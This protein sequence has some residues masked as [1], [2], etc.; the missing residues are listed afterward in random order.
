MPASKG[1]AKPPSGSKSQVKKGKG[2]SPA[3]GDSS[4][5]TNRKNKFAG[6]PRAAKKTW[7]R[8]APGVT[9]SDKPKPP[10]PK[11]PTT[12]FQRLTEQIK[13]VDVVFEVLDARCP[14]ASRHPRSDEIF[15]NKPRVTVLTKADLADM[16]ALKDWQATSEILSLKNQKGKDK[17]IKSALAATESKR[18]AM[19]RRGILP[20]PMRVC[21]VGMPNV[22]KS[23]LINWL[24]GIHKTKVADKPGVTLG[25]QWVRVHPQLELLDTPGILPAGALSKESAIRLA[26][27]NLMPS[28]N[29]ELEEIARTGLAMVHSRYPK[30]IQAYMPGA[31]VD[32]TPVAEEVTLESLARRRSLIGLG[33]Q[34]DH[35]RAASLFLTDLRSGRIGRITLN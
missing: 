35:M 23:S 21:V 2:K 29:Y 14:E 4:A 26:L 34:P 13:W 17:L 8:M 31:V 28:G 18:E 3:G 5:S 33:A 10:K 6:D 12:A 32:K 19:A 7:A 9:T 25:N 27:F 24:I 30:L 16:N 15:G 22:G 1:R 11:V 20:R